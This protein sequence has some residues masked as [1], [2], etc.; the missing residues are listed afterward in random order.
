M[1]RKSCETHGREVIDN[2]WVGGLVKYMRGGSLVKYMDEKS[3]EINMRE[4]IGNKY[5]MIFV[6]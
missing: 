1:G 2:T 3:W 5:R 6:N 4:V